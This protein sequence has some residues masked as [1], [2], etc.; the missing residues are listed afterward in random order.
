M[1]REVT[2]GGKKI[3]EVDFLPT[4]LQ[5]RALI[6]QSSCMKGQKGFAPLKPFSFGGIRNQAMQVF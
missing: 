3:V 4:T 1:L 2:A 6:K 5:Q